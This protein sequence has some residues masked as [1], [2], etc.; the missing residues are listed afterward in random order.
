VPELVG[1]DHRAD[2]LDLP[3]EDVER[4]GVE[5][6]AVPVA[7][8]RARLAVHLV[9]LHDAADPDERRDERGEHPGHVLSADDVAGQLRCLAATVTD[10]VN[11]GGQQL[12]Q[13]VD[14]PFPEGVEESSGEFLALFAV[15]L[16]PGPARVHVAAR[17]HR[18]L[19]ARRLRSLHRRCD[20]PEAEANTSR[21][22]KTARS[23]GESRSSSN[24]AAIDTESASSADRS[25]SW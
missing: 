23:S 1:V 2:R 20:L 24:R 17:L 21:S 12:P 6:L 3:V 22:T 16:E 11:V 5:D 15:G 18:E 13:P 8:D 7:D 4:Q 19:A 25:G 10:H 9:R 14:V